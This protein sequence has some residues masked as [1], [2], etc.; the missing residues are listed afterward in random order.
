MET[1][2]WGIP[3]LLKACKE[4]LG[5]ELGMVIDLSNT[6]KWYDPQEFQPAGVTHVKI[7]IPGKKIPNEGQ[8]QQFFSAV[9]DFCEENDEDKLLG[10]HSTFGGK[11]AGHLIC[12]YLMDRKEVDIEE[13][14]S[15]FNKLTGPE[16]DPSKDMYREG[17]RDR[18]RNRTHPG[19]FPA[20]MDPIASSSSSPVAADTCMTA[21]RPMMGQS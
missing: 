4:D 8:V 7:P 16:A 17:L 12:C 19:T 2:T 14:L 11:R 10:V 6:D 18:H 15:V 9:D 5:C 1:P 20:G 3:N 13:A 21:L